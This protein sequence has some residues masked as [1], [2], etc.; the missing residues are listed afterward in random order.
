MS[1]VVVVCSFLQIILL[2]FD[3][4]LLRVNGSLI[5]PNSIFVVRFDVEV[6]CFL[7]GNLKAYFAKSIPVVVSMLLVVR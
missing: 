6:D 2:V 5:A 3:V 7:F 1:T 4:E